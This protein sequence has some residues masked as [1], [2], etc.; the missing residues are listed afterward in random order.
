MEPA[1]S[2]ESI[3]QSFAGSVALWVELAA[4]VIIA[5]AAVEALYR[6]LRVVLLGGRGAVPLRRKEIWV[7]FAVWLILA[8]EFELAADVIRSAISPTWDQIGQLGAIAGIRT[9]LNFFLERDIKEFAGAE[10]ERA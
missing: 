6:L 9:V 7:R 5:L 10:P 1:R 3:F 8:L 2:L 4:V